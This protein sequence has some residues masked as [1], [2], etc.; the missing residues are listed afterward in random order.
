MHPVKPVSAPAPVAGKLGRV[1]SPLNYA[2]TPAGLTR[3]PPGLTRVSPYSP[4][5]SRY[6]PARS[7]CQYLPNYG[8]WMPL[9]LSPTVS[10][11]MN[12]MAGERLINCLPNSAYREEYPTLS[13]SFHTSTLLDHLRYG[14]PLNAPLGF[15][16]HST[17]L[18]RPHSQIPWLLI[19]APG[20]KASSPRTLILLRQ[21][22]AMLYSCLAFPTY[23]PTSYSIFPHGGDESPNAD[24]R[25]RPIAA[26]DSYE[27]P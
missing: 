19:R 24:H 10:S 12:L 6:S 16:A 15:S 7:V 17:R 18:G 4:V 3:V 13:T 9:R 21:Y 25:G 8:S 11:L 27:R 23:I 20:F 26:G 2:V 5:S 14:N 1:R 22:A